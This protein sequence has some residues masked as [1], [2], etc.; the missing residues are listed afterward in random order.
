[1]R[2]NGVKAAL[3][4]T[5]IVERMVLLSMFAMLLCDVIFPDSR[6]A[7]AIATIAAMLQLWRL[8]GWRGWQT[9][10]QP[11]VWV[12]HLA[13]LWLPL[14]LGLKAAWIAGSYGWAAH[15]QHA[16]GAGAAGMMILAVMTRAS[17]GHTGRPL[18]VHA[19]IAAAYGLLALAVA[20][21]VFGPTFLP[22]GYASVVLVAGVLWIAAF[23]PYLAIYVPILLR[24]R[25]DGKPG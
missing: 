9:A 19:S 22:L 6:A 5:P 14:G 23:V 16:L 11:I 2:A 24:P 25:V 7:I 15:W 18:N 1:L 21:R 13:Y 8:A 20:V 12:L 4:S 10:G 17:L 3:R